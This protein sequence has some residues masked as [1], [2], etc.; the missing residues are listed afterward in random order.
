MKALERDIEMA[1]SDVIVLR[2]RELDHMTQE[3]AQQILD[4][5]LRNRLK[6]RTVAEAR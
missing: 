3:L 4:H 1:P 6:D 5:A 2:T